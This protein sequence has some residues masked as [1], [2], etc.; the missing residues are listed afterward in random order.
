M[1]DKILELIILITNNFIIL[2]KIDEITEQ[3][4]ISSRLNDINL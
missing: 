2:N 1:I 4:N 3:N